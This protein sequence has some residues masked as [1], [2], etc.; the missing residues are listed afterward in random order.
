MERYSVEK[1]TTLQE[2]ATK[3][4]EWE[5]VYKNCSDAVPFLNFYYQYEYLQ[6]FKQGKNF[7]ISIFKKNNNVVAIIPLMFKKIFSTN[8][9]NLVGENY[10]D[11]LNFLVID[12]EKE[13]FFN[14]FFNN[15][16]LLGNNFCLTLKELNYESYLY[17]F[18]LNYKNIA[19]NKYFLNLQSCYILK[20]PS[21]FELHLQNLGKK[22][23]QHLK[24]YRKKLEKDFKVE[25]LKAI[26][27]NEVKKFAERFFILHSTRWKEKKLPGVFFQKKVKNFHLNLMPIL[28]KENILELHCLKINNE[29]QAVIYGY[30]LNKNFYFYQ[31]GFNPEFRNYGIGSIILSYVLENTISD[32]FLSFN[33]LRGGEEYKIR[34]GA[35]K[36]KENGMFILT[37]KNISSF[38]YSDFILWKNNLEVQIKENLIKTNKK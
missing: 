10:A 4:T 13:S 26:T 6:N 18:L 21:T 12:N 24:Y 9:F 17:N 32:K 20:L 29:I 8:A 25:Y 14:F 19:I 3:K 35:V 7:L 22:T 5:I 23:R 28:L 33:F 11:Y 36:Q 16:N 38:I 2:L 37:S 27:E 30:S 1:I 15:L 34:L 31:S